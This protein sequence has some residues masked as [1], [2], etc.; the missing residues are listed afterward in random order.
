MKTYRARGG[1]LDPSLNPNYCDGHVSQCQDFY[2]T[3]QGGSDDEPYSKKQ[4]TDLK[5][6]MVQ[7]LKEI[8]LKP[9]QHELAGELLDSVPRY[10]KALHELAHQKDVSI[11]DIIDSL[12]VTATSKGGSRKNSRHSSYTNISNHQLP[13]FSSA[14]SSDISSQLAGSD[15]D[16]SLNSSY[17]D[18]HQ[19]QCGDS[20]SSCGGGNQDNTYLEYKR[21]KQLYKHLKSD[22]Y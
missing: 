21:L 1:N 17:C 14:S 10:L 15:L 22:K 12:V 18:G 6:E 19:S 3:C 9:K 13:E 8:K 11:E 2:G 16:A 7:A 5:K 4:L 20:Y